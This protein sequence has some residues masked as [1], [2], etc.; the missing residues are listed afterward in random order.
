M[1][2]PCSSTSR[3]GFLLLC[4]TSLVRVAAGG[5]ADEGRRWEGF[6]G[7]ESGLCAES[8]LKSFP[9]LSYPPVRLHSETAAGWART[10]D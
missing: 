2:S 4:H 10:N 7:F 1:S 5:T 9:D 3:V 8:D 6:R